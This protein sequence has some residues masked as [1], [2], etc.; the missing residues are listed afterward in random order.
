MLGTDEFLLNDIFVEQ[1]H[2]AFGYSSLEHIELPFTLK[3]IEYGAFENCKNLK[4][5]N[6]PDRLEYIGKRCF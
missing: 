4:N 6:L 3:E 5:I 1:H 2:G